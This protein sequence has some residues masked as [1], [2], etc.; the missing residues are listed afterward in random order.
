MKVMLAADGSR[1]GLEALRTACRLLSIPGEHRS[2]DVVSIAQG[3]PDPEIRM[4]LERRAARTAQRIVRQLN[5]QDRIVSRPIA[6]SGSPARI[7]IRLSRDY[8]LVVVSTRSRKDAASSIGG[9]LGPV[10]SRVLEHANSSVLLARTAEPETFSFRILAPMDGSASALNALRKLDSMVDLAASDV[11]LLH[12]VETPWIRP[13]DDE[14]WISAGDRDEDE[15]EPLGMI[16]REFIKEAETLL[17]QARD[18]LQRRTAVRTKICK[19]I[20]AE[21]IL[22]EANSEEYELL[23]LATGGEHDLKHRMLGSVT[24][25]VAWNA[26]CSVLVVHPGD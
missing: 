24:S 11:T 15:G 12:V 26:A 7:L 18:T 9:G 13:V 23:V 20:P 8:D 22:A 3:S 17:E 2:V 25:K 16:E 14:D 1:Q 21:E 6:R 4:R 5:D 19:G 10:A